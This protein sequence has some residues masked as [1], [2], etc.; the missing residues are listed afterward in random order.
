MESSEKWKGRTESRMK[1]DRARDEKLQQG[2]WKNSSE[3]AKPRNKDL[4]TYSR[5]LYTSSRRGPLNPR[6]A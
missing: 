5:E 3:P 1:E 6:P 2:L 4:G